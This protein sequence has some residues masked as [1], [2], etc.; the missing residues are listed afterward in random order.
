MIF[1]EGGAKITL[2]PK[3]QMT[4]I[5]IYRQDLVGANVKEARTARARWHVIAKRHCAMRWLTSDPIP[6]AS[7][8]RVHVISEKSRRDAVEAA[9]DIDAA[10]ATYTVTMFIPDGFFSRFSDAEF[11]EL[12]R[13]TKSRAVTPSQ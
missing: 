10:T 4:L 1:P 9:G 11:V 13:L 12:Y 8:R 7:V 6:P 3:Y 5:E 2:P